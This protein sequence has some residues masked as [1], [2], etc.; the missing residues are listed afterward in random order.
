MMLLL[1]LKIT[2]FYHLSDYIM[3]QTITLFI[4]KENLVGK[5]YM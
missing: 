3:R 1:E 2:I 5:L 4:V